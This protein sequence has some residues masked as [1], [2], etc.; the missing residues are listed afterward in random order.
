MTLC[1]L[2]SAAYYNPGAVTLLR[3]N[4]HLDVSQQLEKLL[5]ERRNVF[6][7]HLEPNA[8][9]R[10]TPLQRLLRSGKLQQSVWPEF[11]LRS[12]RN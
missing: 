4:P 11:H 6:I 1:A 12:V 9:L 5:L 2:E 3:T 8:F 10:R 7:L